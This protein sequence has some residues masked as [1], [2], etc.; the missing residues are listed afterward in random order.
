LL[1]GFVAVAEELNFT[2][3]AQRLHLA[4]QALSAQIRQL[5][6]RSGA[7]LLERT[8]RRVE[9]TPAGEALLPAARAVLEALDEGLAAVSRRAGHTRLRVG[10]STTAS[11]ELV[12]EVLRRFGELH[13]DV[14]VAVRNSAFQEPT[15][16]LAE[17]LADVAFVRPPFR[18]DGLEMETVL[19]EPR[20][21]LLPK[22]H[23]LAA[24]ELLR[25]EDIVDEPWIWVDGTD[26]EA[27]AFW[28]LAEHRGGR[29]LRI[30]AHITSFDE[31]FSVVSA[32]LAIGVAPESAI[33]ALGPSFPSLRFIPVEGLEP[34][35][36][37]VAWRSPGESEAIRAFVDLAR[38]LAPGGSDP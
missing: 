26:P 11:V 23:A 5:E 17:G 1:R 6:E 13:P 3:A 30:G 19:S 16:G 15:G 31:Y 36:V 20:M 9:L 32:G 18:A 24:S 22:S 34:A 27:A 38:T 28:T 8:T 14:E 29:L 35:T 7:R 21:A 12:G 37:A 2:R 33:R 4:Q 10:L 25:P